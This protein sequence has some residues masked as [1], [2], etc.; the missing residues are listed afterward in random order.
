MLKSCRDFLRGHWQLVLILLVAGMLRFYRIGDIP[1]GLYWDEAAITYNAW[2]ISLWNRD[3]H[4]IRLPLSFKSYG[5]Y[6]A[7][8]LIYGMAAI[9]KVIGL[10]VPA[11]RLV[12]AMLGLLNV[13][14]VY[15][16]ARRI[17]EHEQSALMAALIMTM[18]PWAVHFSRIGTEATLAMTLILGGVATILWRGTQRFGTAIGMW[19]ISISLYAYH[20]AKIFVPSVLLVATIVLW[21]RRKAAWKQLFTG[22]LVLLV[23]SLPLIYDS[24]WGQGFERGKTLILYQDGKL[25]FSWGVVSRFVEQLM[26]YLAPDFWVRS[27]DVIG[28]RHGVPGHGVMYYSIL[29][30][31]L[32]GVVAALHWRD[33]YRF[34]VVWL[35]LG[36]M[37]ALLSQGNPHAIRSM[38]ALPALVLLAAHGFSVLSKKLSSSWFSALVLVVLLFEAGLYL[39]AYYGSYAVD[40]ATAFQYGYREAILT[41]E[42]YGKDADGFVVTSAYGQPYIYT[43]LY[44]ELSPEQFQFGA[45]ANY[46]FHEIN[47]A[48]LVP[49]HMYVATPEEIPVDNEYVIQVVTIPDTDVPVFVV[50]KT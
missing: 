41:A 13:A 33:R 50:A 1:H 14:L 17:S 46:A 38:M 45:L 23:T 18:V 36:M 30:L 49:N 9:Y 34:V 27:M 42:K 28:L 35:V 4:A 25:D 22:W 24:V 26:S 8:L 43:L 44:R 32:V 48:S 19:L 3:E 6:K 2:G 7:P 31:A 37:P 47:A 5:D 15:V 12:V 40:S 21:K 29:M 20:S 16:I 11:L 10:S 39:L